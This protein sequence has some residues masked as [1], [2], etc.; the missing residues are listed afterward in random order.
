MNVGTFRSW[1]LGVVGGRVPTEGVF[2][3]AKYY[4]MSDNERFPLSLALGF[5]GLTSLSGSSLYMVTSKSF[6]GGI[7]GHLGF[8]TQFNQEQITPS[9]M[10]GVEYFL[11]NQLS[12]LGDF[13]GQ[14]THYLCN[15]GVKYTFWEDVY[16]RGAILDCMNQ[17]SKGMLYSVGISCS[18]YL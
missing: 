15:I 18:K 1:E 7:H 2:V 12:F 5:S 11:S 6:Q 4:L 14:D 16:I 13:D 9:I 10:G 8:R 17:S 3:N